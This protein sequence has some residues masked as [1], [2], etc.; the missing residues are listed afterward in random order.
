MVI[1]MFGLP[2]EAFS[3]MR[4]AGFVAVL[5]SLVIMLAGG[6]DTTATT[7]FIVGLFVGV[8]GVVNNFGRKR[9]EV[10]DRHLAEYEAGERDDLPR[11]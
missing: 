8:A 11:R 10:F 3:Y 9:R 2:Q 4:L 6:D 1:S 5:A 7:L